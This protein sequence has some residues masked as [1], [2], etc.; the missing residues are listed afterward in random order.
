M[1]SHKLI[2]ISLLILL[3]TVLPGEIMKYNMYSKKPDTLSEIKFYKDENLII[4]SVSEI[5]RYSYHRKFIDEAHP[6]IQIKFLEEYLKEFKKQ[7]KL[8]SIS[9]RINGKKKTY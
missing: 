6:I 5:E 4:S 7:K 9:I 8:D 1:N 2:Q 3:A